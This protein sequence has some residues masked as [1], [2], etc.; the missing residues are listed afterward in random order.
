MSSRPFSF[1]MAALAAGMKAKAGR[2]TTRDGLALSI[3]FLG[4]ALRHDDD[5][6][7]AVRFYLDGVA[8]GDQLR[9]GEALVDWV[10]A[11]FPAPVE[12]P[13]EYDWQRRADC[14]R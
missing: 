7:E 6:A 12:D 5:A 3:V 9:A 10:H 2:A 1:P 11:R 14:G 13:P 8:S 4:D